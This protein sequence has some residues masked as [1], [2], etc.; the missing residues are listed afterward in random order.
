LPQL[1]QTRLIRR[2]NAAFEIERAEA[3]IQQVMQ[4]LSYADMSDIADLRKEQ[5]RLRDYIKKLDSELDKIR[6][7]FEATLA[8]YKDCIA[9]CPKKVSYCPMPPA[10]QA[11]AIGSRGEVGSGARMQQKL[12]ETVGGMLG[13]MLGG[14]AG[15]LFGGGGGGGDDKPDTKDDPV[16]DSDKVGMTKQGVPLAVGAKFNGDGNLVVSNTIGKDAPGSG[17]FQA[18]FLQDAEGRRMIP[19]RLEIYELWLEWTLTVHWTHDT[20]VNGE[21]VE[22]SEG[23]WQKSGRET[24]GY[25]GVLT[26]GKAIEESIWRRLGFSNAS[27][28]VRSLG[29]IFQV[30]AKDLAKGPLNLVVHATLPEKDPVTTVPMIFTLSKGAGDKVLVTPANQT[31][32]VAN[33]CVPGKMPPEPAASVSKSAGGAPA[34]KPAEPVGSTRSK[35]NE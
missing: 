3:E 1:A 8:L 28:G 2:A 24:L 35:D 29:A 15:G 21:H 6:Q 33:G 4:Q 11:V 16:P 17:T 7:N 31:L 20:W 5:A 12:K 9:K 19:Y 25:L 14:K 10:N 18:V 27:H 32:A 34:S 22:H 30:T 26:R 23:G 13:G